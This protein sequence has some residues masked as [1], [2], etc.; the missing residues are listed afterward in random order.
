MTA[1][2]G[3]TMERDSDVL[4]VHFPGDKSVASAAAAFVAWR[5]K[6]NQQT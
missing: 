4:V 2:H 3:A 6:I 5:K 1:F